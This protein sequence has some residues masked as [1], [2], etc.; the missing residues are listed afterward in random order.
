M[1]DVNNTWNSSLFP[2]DASLTN[3]WKADRQPEFTDLIRS[4]SAIASDPNDS[5]IQ[6]TIGDDALLGTSEADWIV[7]GKGNDYLNGYAGDDRLW[8]G[9]G[10]N[11]LF[12]GAGGDLLLGK[13]VKTN[14]MGVWERSIVG[15]G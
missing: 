12:G 8:G 10:D 5:K 9:T 7:G 14:S 11:R 3:F 6:G 13:M 15:C 1:L 2:Q 4:N